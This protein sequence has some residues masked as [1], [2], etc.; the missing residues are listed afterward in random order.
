M[1]NIRQ[2]KLKK[3]INKMILIIGLILTIGIFLNFS[4]IYNS[5]AVDKDTDLYFE[6]IVEK[7]D[8]LWTIADQYNENQDIRRLIYEIKKLNKL[9]QTSIYPGQKLVIPAM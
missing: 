9:N 3:V 2:S 5:Y 4:S 6:V 8:T 7:G 1:G